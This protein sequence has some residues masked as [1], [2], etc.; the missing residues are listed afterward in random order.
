VPKSKEAQ[1]TAIVRQI[2]TCR[3]KKVL[4]TYRFI[5]QSNPDIQTA[6]NKK[7]EEFV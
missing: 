7:M 6:Y 3:E 2:G 1:V 4:E 5:A